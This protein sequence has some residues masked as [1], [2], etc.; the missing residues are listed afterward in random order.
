MLP[1]LFISLTVLF[2]LVSPRCQ[3]RQHESVRALSTCIIDN[4]PV[5]LTGGTDRSLRLWN[6]VDPTQCCCVVRPKLHSKKITMD[7][8]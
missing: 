2:L 7:Y 4:C 5:V 8:Q 1:A 3:A 6:L